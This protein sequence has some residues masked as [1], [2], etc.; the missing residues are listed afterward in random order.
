MSVT[1]SKAA[2]FA[3]FNLLLLLIAC[4]G[5]NISIDKGEDLSGFTPAFPALAEGGSS[6]SD[7]V[8]TVL[9]IPAY[10]SWV[11]DN[12]KAVK[13]IGTIRYELLYQP[14]DYIL[15]KDRQNG[16]GTGATALVEEE[17][18]P[19][20]YFV[21]TMSEEQGADLLKSN[22]LNG[23][24]YQ[25]RLRY[26]SFEMDKDIKLIDGKDTLACKLYHFE[27]TY[28]IAPYQKMV[29]A[30]DKGEDPAA[31]KTFILHDQL[32][33]SG[34]VKIKFPGKLFTLIPDVAL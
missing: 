8:R 24:S 3:I 4:K 6:H 17:E 28:D 19:F 22:A 27:R 34:F 33:G 1:M 9:N 10:F 7:D 12:L 29:L 13:Q 21:L 11:N 30:F 25:E 32:N 18:D 5:K 14:E 23:S 20:Q 16:I 26:Y 31:D 2:L 15:L